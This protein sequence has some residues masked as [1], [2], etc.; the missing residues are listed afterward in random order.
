MIK[1]FVILSLVGL[2]AIMSSARADGNPAAPTAEQVPADKQA[3]ADTEQLPPGVSIVGEKQPVPSNTEE[4][5]Q[6]VGGGGF[7]PTGG[8]SYRWRF[9]YQYG[10]GIRYGWRYPLGY[11]NTFGYPLFGSNCVFGRPWGGYFYC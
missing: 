8:I 3:P 10:G 4:L 9:S 2:V 11:W 1:R 6:F 7:I 5:E